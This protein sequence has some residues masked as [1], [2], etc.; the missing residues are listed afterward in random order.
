MEWTKSN[1]SSSELEQKQ[2]AYIKEALE[3]AKR[4]LSMQ[5]E[6]M[7]AEKAAAE[8]AAAEKAA[9]EKAAAGKVAAEKAAAEKAAAEKVAAEKAA[10]EKAAAEKAAAEKAAAEKAAAEKVAAEKAAAEKAAAE[11]AAAEKAAAE[12]AAAEKAAA[13]KA[14]EEFT[15]LS[16][17]TE[18]LNEP[19][20]EK[21][22]TSEKEPAAPAPVFQMLTANR[23][24]EKEQCPKPE[25]DNAAVSKEEK[26]GNDCRNEQKDKNC[27]EDII[28]IAARKKQ[29]AAQQQ[30]PNSPA[31]FNQYINQHNRSQCNCPSCQKKRAGQ[32]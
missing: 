22:E 8:K 25:Q 14:K 3:M 20:F 2:Q 15:K 19:V 21:E 29:Q 10:A 5:E 11:K 16:E 4:S 32:Q 26:N 27:D 18:D 1:I 23:D 28:D 30:R 9:A 7:I 6:K 31:N 17:K 24:E 12:R 13:E